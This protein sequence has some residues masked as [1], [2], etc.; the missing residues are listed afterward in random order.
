MTKKSAVEWLYKARHNYS[1]DVECMP[2]NGFTGRLHI[3][4]YYVWN[5]IKN[6]L[7]IG[8]YFRE[9]GGYDVA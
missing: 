5:T 2:E 6:P 4:L 9:L 7:F 1:I 3:V 8:D